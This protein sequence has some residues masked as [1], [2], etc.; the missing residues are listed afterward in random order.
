[1]FTDSDGDGMSDDFENKNG[2]DYSDP[3]DADADLDGDGL[4]N[5]EEMNSGTNVSKADTDQDDMS[6]A[7]DVMS[8]SSS[9]ES[10][11]L[12][13]SSSNEINT[14]KDSKQVSETNAL[15]SETNNTNSNSKSI[16]NSS[17]VKTNSSD[18]SVSSFKSG[19][20]IYYFNSGSSYINI[21]D[22]LLSN[23]SKELLSTSLSITLI[24]HTDNSGSE[25][26]NNILSLDRANQVSNYFINK[27]IPK[28]RITTK[29][30]GESE[31]LFTNDTEENKR[32]NRGVQ[33]ILN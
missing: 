12:N 6:N 8:S 27:G 3:T 25:E 20:N 1:M 4:S 16:Q 26:L 13:S 15:N 23:I 33:I 9:D 10:N 30:Q 24:G 17:V 31:P 19:D 5:V 11:G 7:D 2:L 29:G 28:S 18:V 14:D 22:K 32:K 21:N